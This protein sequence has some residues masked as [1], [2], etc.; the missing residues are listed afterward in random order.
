MAEEQIVPEEEN[1]D[2]DQMIFLFMQ[3]MK[4]GYGNINRILDVEKAL[5]TEIASA[6][7]DTLGQLALMQAQLMLGNH[8]KAKA[9]AY[10]LWDVG[11]KLAEIEE[12]IYINN[13]MN[14]GFVEMASVLLKPKFEAL[15]EHIDFFYPLLLKFSTMTGNIALLERLITHPKAPEQDDAYLQIVNLY[16]NYKYAEHFKNVQKIVLDNTK[17]YLCTYDYDIPENQVQT[18]IKIS[19]YLTG[20]MNEVKD[21]ENTVNEKIREYYASAG[22]SKLSSY[23]LNVLP[24]SSHPS[25]DVV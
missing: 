15:D 19:I 20:Q 22:I 4:T 16:K 23:S 5:Y 6:P 14:L 21:M 12:Y 11:P 18:E 1:Y 2:D 9:I 3:L 7:D 8:E 24:I 10:K 17:E 25:L 13:L